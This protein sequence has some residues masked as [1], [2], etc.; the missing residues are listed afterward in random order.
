[1]L[2]KFIRCSLLARGVQLKRRMRLEFILRL[3]GMRTETRYDRVVGSACEKRANDKRFSEAKASRRQNRRRRKN[4][5]IPTDFICACRKYL[6][7]NVR[8]A[9][10]TP[11][12]DQLI[13]TQS[14][15]QFAVQTTELS[16]PSVE[17]LLEGDGGEPSREPRNHRW[18]GITVTI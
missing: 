16:Q 2:F 18:K 10:F 7:E 12:S 6:A 14:S 5:F 4:E 8:L 9:L 15:F 13:Y 17:Q 1:M 3:A 11:N